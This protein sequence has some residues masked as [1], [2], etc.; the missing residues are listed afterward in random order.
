[1]T[2]LNNTP[3]RLLQHR[4]TSL[5]GRR[6]QYIKYGATADNLRAAATDVTIVVIGNWYRPLLLLLLL[7]LY[8]VVSTSL[9][10]G[11]TE[12]GP[13]YRRF[14]FLTV[15][16]NQIKCKE[17][18]NPLTAERSSVIWTDSI[19]FWQPDKLLTLA[20]DSLDHLHSYPKTHV[21]NWLTHSKLQLLIG[22]V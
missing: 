1:M 7:L 6:R 5:V 17:R 22:I 16:L 10:Q 8:G 14:C 12:V 13:N 3:T 19:D 18:I 21:G 20:W 9:R 2:S 15:S 4:S 11:W